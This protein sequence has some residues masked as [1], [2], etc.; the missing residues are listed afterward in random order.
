MIIDDLLFAAVLRSSSCARASG[1]LRLRACSLDSR[2]TTGSPDAGDRLRACKVP[3]AGCQRAACRGY[4]S[5]GGAG[6]GRVG[7][8]LGEPEA[9]ARYRL[10]VRSGRRTDGRRHLRAPKSW[11]ASCSASARAAWLPHRR[12]A[13]GTSSAAV[14]REDAARWCASGQPGAFWACEASSCGIFTTELPLFT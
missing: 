14:R 1:A 11:S 2:F 3:P 12:H 13:R 5:R 4:G 7:T 10:H 9:L 6:T 8:C